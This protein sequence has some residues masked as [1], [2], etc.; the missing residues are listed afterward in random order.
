MSTFPSE[1]L[2]RTGLRV[3]VYE[4]ELPEDAPE[5]LYF[6]CR[7]GLVFA[8]GL[9]ALAVRDYYEENKQE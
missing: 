9:D 1:F 8:D 2:D 3:S 4:K 5:R 7:D 6:M